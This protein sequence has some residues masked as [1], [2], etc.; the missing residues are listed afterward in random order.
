MCGYKNQFHV[1]CASELLFLA[2]KD[3]LDS[4]KSFVTHFDHSLPEGLDIAHRNVCR[5]KVEP[6]E[7]LYCHLHL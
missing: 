2:K 3:K 1:L 7:L 6:M 5:T 4:Q